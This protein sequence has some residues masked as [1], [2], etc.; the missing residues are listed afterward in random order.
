MERSVAAVKAKKVK[1]LNL[2][3]IDKPLNT[4]KSMTFDLSHEYS[5]MNLSKTHINSCPALAIPPTS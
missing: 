1:S 2:N 4:A 5:G 3:N